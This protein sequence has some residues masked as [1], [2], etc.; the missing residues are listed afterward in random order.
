MDNPISQYQKRLNLLDATFSH[1]DHEDAMVA[2]VYKVTKRT[3]EQLI[4]KICP[5]K[6]DYL[7]EV[8]FLNYLAD[9]IPVPRIL[10]LVQPEVGI[11]GAILMECLPGALLK[12][13]D[14]TDSL[15]YEMGSH[16]A[17][18]HL[19]GTAGYGDLIQPEKL[20]ADPRSYFTLKFEEGLDECRNH[21]PNGLIAQCQHYFG[22]H[23]DLLAAVDGPCIVH[24]DFRPGNLMV[25]EGKLQGI[26]DWSGARGSFAEEDFCP[27]EHGIW[28]IDPNRKKSF[29]AGYASVRPIP[30]YSA[31]MPLLRLSRAVA[32]I[33]FTIKRG[34]WA[35]RASR[36]YQFNRQFLE[37]FFLGGL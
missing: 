34:T 14:F 27:I 11:H 24:R 22:T 13:T 19:N 30:D 23:V 1:I 26:I 20:S 5:R 36:I 28:P 3:G 17:R 4:L 37:A 2:I 16:L 7:R 35:S 31:I 6:N 15:A 25:F 32:T 12:I 8:Y 10:E 18:I 9:K 21:L 33:G 29:L